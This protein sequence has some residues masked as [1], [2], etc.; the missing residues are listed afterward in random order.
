MEE[1]LKKQAIEREKS[2][3]ERVASIA[4]IDTLS[5]KV[6]HLEGHLLDERLRVSKLAKLRRFFAHDA[7]KCKRT[8]CP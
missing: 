5:K 8:T 6:E 7:K 1:L 3:E 2:I 4:E